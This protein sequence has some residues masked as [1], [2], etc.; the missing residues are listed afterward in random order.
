MGISIGHN[1]KNTYDNGDEC[2]PIWKRRQMCMIVYIH[3]RKNLSNRHTDRKG[4]QSHAYNK[5]KEWYEYGTEHKTHS[6]RN[7]GSTTG[8]EENR[9]SI[10]FFHHTGGLYHFMINTGGLSDFTVIT[11]GL[12][13]FFIISGIYLISWSILGVY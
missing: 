2:V 5:F 11:G 13:N 9:G 8:R 4:G 7:T 6:A 3:T 12:S 1:I 10:Y